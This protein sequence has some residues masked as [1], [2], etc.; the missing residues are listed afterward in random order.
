MMSTATKREIKEATCKIGSQSSS[1]SVSILATL[2]IAVIKNQGHYY[3]YLRN[4]EV[5]MSKLDE[6]CFHTKY[7]TYKSQFW[8]TL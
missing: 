8:V 6:N 4:L 7:T 3:I 2:N 5:K 1:E